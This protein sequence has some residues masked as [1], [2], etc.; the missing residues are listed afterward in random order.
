M[1]IKEEI[2]EEEDNKEKR[3]KKGQAN[4]EDETKVS[5]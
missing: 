3:Q 5:S 2:E 4:H 1:I